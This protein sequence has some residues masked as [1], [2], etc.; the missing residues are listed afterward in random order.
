MELLELI[1]YN[2]TFDE[3]YLESLI[4]RATPKWIGIEAD[5]WLANMREG[6]C[7]PLTSATL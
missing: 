3:T 7:C 5:V 6:M 2:P 4:S 1:D